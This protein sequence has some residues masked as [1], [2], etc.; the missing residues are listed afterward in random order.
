MPGGF[1]QREIARLVAY[2]EGNDRIPAEAKRRVLAQ[3]QEAK[4]PA[5]VVARLESRMGG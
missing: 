1:L 3:L 5:E 4:V 2:V